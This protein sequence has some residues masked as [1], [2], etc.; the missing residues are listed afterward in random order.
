MESFMERLRITKRQR[1]GFMRLQ[2]ERARKAAACPGFGP[3][4]NRWTPTVSAQLSVENK[5]VKE[6]IALDAVVADLA[7]G[8]RYSAL[9]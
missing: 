1:Y 4:A 5:R 3:K 8:N 6:M 9:L 7:V 2:C